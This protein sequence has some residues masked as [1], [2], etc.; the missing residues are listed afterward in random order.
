MFFSM[1][2]NLAKHSVFIP[3]N[4]NGHP[5]SR[6]PFDANYITLLTLV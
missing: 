4:E 3:R 5:L 6:C 2:N 1:L